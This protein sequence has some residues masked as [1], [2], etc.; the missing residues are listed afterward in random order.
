MLQNTFSPTRLPVTTMSESAVP[1]QDQKMAMAPGGEPIDGISQLFVADTTSRRYSDVPTPP[2][3][4]NGALVKKNVH[5]PSFSQTLLRVSRS[6]ISPIGVPHSVS[7]HS[8]KHQPVEQ[9]GPCQQRV[10]SNVSFQ[11][12]LTSLHWWWPCFESNGIPC[13]C[14][15]VVVVQPADCGLIILQSDGLAILLR[16]ALTL[17]RVS[18]VV[19]AHVAICAVSTYSRKKAKATHPE[20]IQRMSPCRN[21]VPCHF[22]H[23]SISDTGISWR[24]TADGGSPCFFS[25]L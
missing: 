24:V 6:H 2:F 9:K 12:F 13:H 17:L 19:P 14:G 23:S 5:L 18:I 10:A 20:R 15:E 16:S 1:R 3:T 7:S 21:D 11:R 4:C 22:R 25:Y 8:C